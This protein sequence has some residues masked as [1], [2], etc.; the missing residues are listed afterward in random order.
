MKRKKVIA[1]TLAA[2]MTFSL[3][4]CGGSDEGAAETPAA[5]T[6]E[7][8]AAEAPAAEEAAPETEAEAPAEA[9]VTY[10][11][12]NLGEDYKDLTTTIKFIHHKTD[13]EEDGTMADLISNFNAVYPNITVETEGI[14]DY[15]ED[16]LLRLS[17][18]EWGDVMFIPAVD[19]AELPTYFVPYGTVSEMSELV[20]FADQWKNADMCYGVGYMGNAQGILY[21]KKVFA[22]AGITEL[23]KTPDEFIAALQAIKDNTDAIPLYTNYAAGWTMGGQWDAYLGAITTSDETWLNQKFVHTAEP[24][25]DNGDGT[26]AYALYKILYDA[27]AQGLIEDDYTT[28]DW[29]G[30]KPMINNGEIGTMVLGS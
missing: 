20:N 5:T 3:A 19:A 12:I 25:K 7:G 9:G 10:A 21:N 27:T 24:F 15:Q 17:T 4:A 8:E 26:G 30:C 11:S 22:D 28:T 23:P 18:G 13:R 2:T 6:D 1:L 16:S 14:T 29:E